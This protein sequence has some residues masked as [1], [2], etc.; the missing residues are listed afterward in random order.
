MDA[1]AETVR[2]SAD[3][4]ALKAHVEGGQPLGGT[5]RV[6]GAKNSATRLLA[7]AALT[8]EAVTLT[9]APTDLVDLN[10]K[11]RFLRQAGAVITTRR[12][13]EALDVVARD[14]GESPYD[15]G[16]D[17]PIR[18]TYLLVAGQIRKAGRARVPYPGGCRIGARGYDLHMM[19][20]RNLGCTV[21][22]HP[23]FIEVVGDGF[24]GGRIA[25]PISTVGGTENALLCAAIARGP[26]EIVNAYI[27]PEI[28]D[29]IDLLRRMGARI[30]VLGNS[31]VRVE[32]VGRLSG[33]RKSVMPDRIEA[34]TWIVL[35]LM[36]RADLR[37]DDVPFADMQI[38]FIHL[39]KVG[40]DL[41]RNSRSVH[42]HPDSIGVRGL[43]PFEVACGTHPGVISDM[44]PFFVL[45]G[46]I[47]DGTSRIFDY[48]Y[49]ERI[50]YA[51]E[52]A[53]ACPGGAIEAVAGRIVAHGPAG[54]RGATMRSTDLRGSM[55]MLMVAICADGRSTVEDVQMALRGYNRLQDKLS[56]LGVTIDI[57]A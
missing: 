30:E 18:T 4:T 28:D 45:L 41:F 9:N 15:G 47:A 17:F 5:V 3:G 6:S 16:D 55:A 54:F 44:Q 56:T 7:A 50:A 51:A 31:L 20:W 48:R 37:I 38:P 19:V 23:A 27:T 39:E 21:T 25:F 34:L 11:I 36:A 35:A 57:E 40:V 49:P 52:I 1:C 32:G 8:D 26:T 46:L 33:A 13:E 22:E 53:K 12:Q 14:L 42:V 43:Q 10:H 29:L 24:R 2:S